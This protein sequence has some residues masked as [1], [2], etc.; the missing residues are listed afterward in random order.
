MEVSV[1]G[2]R[3][4]GYH[5]QPSCNDF[6]CVFISR[7]SGESHHTEVY[8]SLSLIKADKQWLKR[9]G[10]LWW[11]LCFIFS[12][13]KTASV[14]FCLTAPFP[15][16]DSLAHEWD[17]IHHVV[18]KTRLCLMEEALQAI[19]I[20]W[21]TVKQPAVTTGAWSPSLPLWHSVL[22]ELAAMRSSCWSDQFLA[23]VSETQYKDYTHCPV[24]P[25]WK[26]YCTKCD[27]QV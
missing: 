17:V 15:I 6:V 22:V 1:N 19:C 18:Q 8:K 4:G 7:P 13:G 3:S 5:V 27:I 12:S 2:L 14:E 23:G 21:S 16:Y 25:H 24:Y 10:L 26:N 20:R 11:D 9:Y